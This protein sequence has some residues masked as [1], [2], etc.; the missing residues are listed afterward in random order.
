MI[1]RI[2]GVRQP[3]KFST[4]KLAKKQLN[5]TYYYEINMQKSLFYII[6]NRHR[7]VE[8]DAIVMFVVVKIRSVRN[9]A[10]NNE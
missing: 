6:E 9:N 3:F 10:V 2:T 7:Y 8:F 4:K 1:L 5:C